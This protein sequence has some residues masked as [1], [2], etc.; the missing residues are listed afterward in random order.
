MHH[1]RRFHWPEY[2]SC[3]EVVVRF[4]DSALAQIVITL[5]FDRFPADGLAFVPMFVPHPLYSSTPRFTPTTQSP[6]PVSRASRGWLT[7]TCTAHLPICHSHAGPIHSRYT[8]IPAP[9]LQ[10]SEHHPSRARLAS[11]TIPAYPHPRLRSLPTELLSSFENNAA[12]PTSHAPRSSVFV[13]SSSAGVAAPCRRQRAI[14][15]QHRCRLRQTTPS[16]QTCPL[17][18]PCKTL[19]GPLHWSCCA[20]SV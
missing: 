18:R 17:A 3:S 14:E 2:I 16:T 8:L 12:S 6:Y 5:K 4:S 19:H 7:H 11:W 15:I 9:R 20:A 13:P 1:Q 10:I